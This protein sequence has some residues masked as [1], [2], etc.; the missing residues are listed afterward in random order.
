[1]D[2]K[3]LN[4]LN[5][6]TKAIPVVVLTSSKEEGDIIKSYQS[7]VNSYIVKPVAFDQFVLSV[8]NLGLYWLLLNES[9]K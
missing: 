2:W 1:M 8:S 5:D 6:R 4:R 3:C 9:P 7:G